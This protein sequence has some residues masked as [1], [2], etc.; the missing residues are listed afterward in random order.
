MS[1]KFFLWL[2]L[3]WGTFP[4]IARPGNGDSD[5]LLLPL[6]FS[7]VSPVNVP[8]IFS[9]DLPFFFPGSNRAGSYLNLGYSMAN[10]WH[11]QASFVYPQN[12]TP[13]QKMQV[14]EVHY[15]LRPEFFELMKI[16]TQEK[17]FQTDGVLQHFRVAWQKTW[18]NRSSLILNANLHMLNG[19]RSPLNFL[20]SDSFIE[21]FHSNFA[22]EDNYGRRLYPFN[23]ATIEF[24]DE[25]G[26][27]YR[28]EKGDVFTGVLDAHYYRGLY[29]VAQPGFHLDSQLGLH[30]SVPLNHFH[31]YVM[32]GISLGGR[33][34][35]L[36]GAN[37]SFI[38]AADGGITNQTG[39]KIGEGVRA[40][41]RKFRRH[42]KLYLGVN[43]LSKNKNATIIGVLN[44]FQGSFMKGAQTA[45]GEHGYQDL[46]V[47]FLQEG[48]V[49][50]GEPVTQEFWLARLTPES[51]YYHSV[52]TYFIFG[53]H[54]QG[55]EFTVY[56]GEDLFFINN[57]PDIQFG[58]QYRIPLGGNK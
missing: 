53:F 48:D 23:R 28:K 54:K 39:W 7:E 4:A 13:Y 57:A 25:L 1:G 58:F 37:S 5:V 15:A 56:A 29:R 47:R 49:W 21:A 27:S 24:V 6:N 20:A 8:G 14:S 17:M 43:F 38:I 30:L 35:Y 9:L 42:L 46:G 31:P 22:I 50:E 36:L 55:R 41:D 52:K 51:V 10:T 26:N 18:K 32:P 2:V 11:P 3:L 44:N 40:I 19:G 45:G 34:D 12:L 16:E 33:T